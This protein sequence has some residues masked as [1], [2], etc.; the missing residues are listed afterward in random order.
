[1]RFV[2]SALSPLM[3]P[4]QVQIVWGLSLTLPWSLI[5][6]LLY[7]PGFLPRDRR[8]GALLRGGRDAGLMCLLGILAWPGMQYQYIAPVSL[9]IALEVGVVAV[10]VRPVWRRGLGR[11]LQIVTGALA[12]LLAAIS[13][14]SV[15]YSDSLQGVCVAALGL[16]GCFGLLRAGGTAEAEEDAS[17]EIKYA[18][19]AMVGATAVAVF[20]IVPPLSTSDNEREVGQKVNQLVPVG[21]QVYC[22]LSIDNLAAYTGHHVVISAPNDARPVVYAI[23]R[24]DD[25]VTLRQSQ[26]VG[27]QELYAFNYKMGWKRDKATLHLVRLAA[28][29]PTASPDWQGILAPVSKS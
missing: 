22:P 14:T 25:V 6:P 21:E 2:S 8:F 16:V 20:C 7:Y 24:D 28:A 11:G 27:I 13:V 15:L 26:K 19:S 12:V 29:L 9:L 17:R 1:M 3:P 10:T 4:H 23:L 18:L 5:Y